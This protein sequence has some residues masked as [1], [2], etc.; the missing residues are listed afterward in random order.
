MSDIV[1]RAIALWKRP[2]PEGAEAT[3]LFGTVYADPVVING[4]STTAEQLVDRA[5]ATHVALADLTMEIVD[6]VDVGDRCAVVFRQSG[7]HVGRLPGGTGEPTRE[8]VTGLGIDLFTFAEDRIAQ[9]W[10]VSD[11]LTRL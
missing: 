7:V 8:R 5:R 2:P 1:E 4:V 9:I 11:L 3:E 10:V 6:R